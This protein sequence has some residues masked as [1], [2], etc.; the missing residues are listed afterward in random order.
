MENIL[1]HFGQNWL[2]IFAVTT[3]FSILCHF[4]W[5]VFRWERKNHHNLARMEPHS[6]MVMN[7]IK[8]PRTDLFVKQGHQVRASFLTFCILVWLNILRALSTR[9]FQRPGTKRTRPK[10]NGIK[11][12]DVLLVVMVDC[13][14]QRYVLSGVYIMWI[15]LLVRWCTA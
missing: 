10:D 12:K 5:Y 15:F 2:L 9:D 3:L 4:R 7:C 6:V 14:L 8:T 11:P 13:R 1:H